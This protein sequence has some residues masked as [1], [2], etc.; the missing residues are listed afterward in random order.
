MKGKGKRQTDGGSRKEEMFREMFFLFI[1]L[2]FLQ[3]GTRFTSPD[4]K[5][6]IIFSISLRPLRSSKELREYWLPPTDESV[7]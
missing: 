1:I 5:D 4:S 6:L 7:W 3:S 2:P